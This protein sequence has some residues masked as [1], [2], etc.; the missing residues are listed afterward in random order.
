IQ[1]G[2][3]QLGLRVPTVA[4][5]P[6]IPA[7][8]LGSLRYPNQCLDHTALISTVREILGPAGAPLAAL[9]RRDASMPSLAGLC[10]LPQPRS[11]AET[12]DLDDLAPPSAS[13]AATAP[14]PAAQSAAA[15]TTSSA[16]PERSLRG[17]ARI[18]MS[19]DLAIAQARN[20]NPIAKARPELQQCTPADGVAVA[21]AN[22]PQR[23]SQLLQYIQAVAERHRSSSTQLPRP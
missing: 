20:I 16:A 22:L 17:F 14:A 8:S 21:S 23:T 13:N 15:P 6:W 4:I 7:G 18:A 1:F 3:D 11:R 10:E 12:P 5:S 2:F 19:L 9:T